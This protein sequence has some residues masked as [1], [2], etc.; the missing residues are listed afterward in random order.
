[1][2]FRLPYETKKKK[3]ND[4]RTPNVHN[5]A[6]SEIRLQLFII[7]QVHKRKQGCLFFSRDSY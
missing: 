2:I 3:T 7:N 5:I 6:I 1:M 4:E